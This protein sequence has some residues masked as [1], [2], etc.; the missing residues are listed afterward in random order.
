MISPADLIGGETVND[1]RSVTDKRRAVV[2]R[3]RGSLWFRST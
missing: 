1:K 2:E 3:L